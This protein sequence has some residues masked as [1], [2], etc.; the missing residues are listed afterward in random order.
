M[1]TFK[2]KSEDVFKWFP[3]TTDQFITELRNSES[4]NSKYS[5]EKMQWYINWGFLVKKAKTDEEKAERLIAYEAKLRLPY[6]ERLNVELPRIKIDVAF[7]AG[8]YFKSDRTN[9]E[10]PK[11]IL[12]MAREIIKIM[13]VQE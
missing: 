9:E 13:M 1:V 7:K 8:H 12:D 5:I 11:F 6:E 10:T 4:Q 3:K 2:P